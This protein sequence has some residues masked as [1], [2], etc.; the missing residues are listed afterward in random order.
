MVSH[1]QDPQ[2]FSEQPTPKKRRPACKN[3]YFSMRHCTGL[4]E[5]FLFVCFLFFFFFKKAKQLSKMS[6][7]WPRHSFQIAS[8]LKKEQSLN[9]AITQR[10]WKLLSRVQL[11]ATPWTVHC[12]APL[13]M[14]FPSQECCSGLPF[15]SPGDLP[16]PG[17]EPESPA[18]EGG[19]STTDPTCKAHSK[20]CLYEIK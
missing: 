14:G 15:P 10:E 1:N 17:M 9:L 4:Q 3:Q 13:S 12:Q 16:G 8:D 5:G 11:F 7:I 2:S 20:H 19:F 6:F 18:L